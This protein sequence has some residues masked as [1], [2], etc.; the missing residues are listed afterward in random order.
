MTLEQWASIGE[1]AA[2]LAVVVSLIYVARQLG[3]N[4]ALMKINASAERLQR[5]F[6]IGAPLIESSEVTEIWLKGEK[7]FDSLS[8]ADRVRLMLFERRAILH[9]HNMFGLRNQKLLSDADWNEMTW[10][11]R[12]LACRRQVVRETWKVFR[13]SFEVPFQAF[14]DEQFSITD[15]TPLGPAPGRKQPPVNR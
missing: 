9:W 7:E 11:I 1:I 2:S 14:I 6:D 10:L 8:E 12:N 5:D 3:Q 13:D 15:R 4:A